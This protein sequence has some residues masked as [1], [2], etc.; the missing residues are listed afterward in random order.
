VSNFT[1][2]LWQEKSMQGNV[3]EEMMMIRALQ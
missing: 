3:F 2:I 1:A